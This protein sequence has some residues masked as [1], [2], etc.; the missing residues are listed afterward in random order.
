M[1][2]I[3]TAVTRRLSSDAGNITVHPNVINWSNRGLGNVARIKKNTRMT[4]IVFSQNQTSGGNLNV[5]A[6]ASTPGDVVML[7][8]EFLG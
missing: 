7:S 2:R 6:A 8:G 1:V 3:R 4:T 5:G